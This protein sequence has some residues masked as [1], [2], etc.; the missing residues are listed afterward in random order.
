MQTLLLDVVT[1]DLAVDTAG[2]IAVAGN[3]YSQAQDAASAIRTFEGEVY[4]DT[5]LG[6]PYFTEILGYSPPISLMKA[7]F[8]AA[9]LTVPG[10]TKSQSFITSWKD[11]V[12][13][14]QVQIMN[15]DGQVSATGF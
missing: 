9:A 11:R 2:N 7:R 3:P 13:S 4:F 1:W 5:T 14:G 8:N 12:V 10:V 15:D 6:I